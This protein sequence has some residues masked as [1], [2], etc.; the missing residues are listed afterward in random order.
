MSFSVKVVRSSGEPAV[1][2]GMMSDYGILGGCDERRTDGDGLV[3]FH[4][5]DDKPRTIWVHG[6]TMGEHSQAN[7]KSYSLYY[8]TIKPMIRCQPMGGKRS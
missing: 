3:E 5:H 2:V 1:D 8:V 6:E 4:N 7:G